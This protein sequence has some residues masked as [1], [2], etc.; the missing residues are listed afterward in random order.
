M[1]TKKNRQGADK[2]SER[3]GSRNKELDLSDF[4][5]NQM[6]EELYNIVHFKVTEL[7]DE[8]NTLKPLVDQPPYVHKAIKNLT[9]RL[10]D[11]G[12]HDADGCRSSTCC[13]ALRS[14]TNS[15][16]WRSLANLSGRSKNSPGN[17]SQPRLG[18][19]PRPWQSTTMWSEGSLD[20]YKLL[21]LL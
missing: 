7:F 18:T 19:F 9:V 5:I 13:T 15:R 21:I 16:R 8:H 11:S 14:L 1:K 3:V 12:E 17:P 4:H 6:I 20:L 10:R 2:A